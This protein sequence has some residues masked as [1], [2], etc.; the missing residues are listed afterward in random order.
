[1]SRSSLTFWTQCDH[2]LHVEP[3]EAMQP[4]SYLDQ[5]KLRQIKRYKQR[6]KNTSLYVTYTWYLEK[7]S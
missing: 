4:P 2:T 7:L 5:V 6:T 1:M 3:A